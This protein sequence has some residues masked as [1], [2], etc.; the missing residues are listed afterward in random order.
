MDSLMNLTRLLATALVAPLA[1]SGCMN[2]SIDAPF[3]STVSVSPATLVV[4]NGATI[5]YEDNVGIINFVDVT[6]VNSDAMPLENV[7][8]EVSGPN[9]GLFLI[10]QQAIEAV[11]YPLAPEDFKD[12]RAEVC[13]DENGEFDNTE[14]WCAWYYDSLSGSYFDLGQS[15]TAGEG[16]DDDYSFRPN[17]YVGKTDSRGRMRLWY[18]LDAMP[19][20]E[21][22]A[23]TVTDTAGNTSTSGG[24]LGIAGEHTLYITIGVDAT[25]FVVTGQ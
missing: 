5:W 22:G 9:F 18:F 17:Y 6:V 10:P 23:S 14:D 13:Y 7:K 1:L 19:I 12:Q 2:A 11:D 20:E 16:D 15:Y 4:G 8:V 21:E 25:T 3:G 24:E